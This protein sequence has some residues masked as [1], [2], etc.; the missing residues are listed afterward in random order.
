MSVKLTPEHFGD[1]TV[2]GADG[3]ITLGDGAATMRDT[4]RA[5]VDDGKKKLVLVVADVSYIDSSGLGELVCGHTYAKRKGAKIKLAT[6]TK[7]VYDLLQITKLYVVFE[8]FDDAEAAVRSF[9]QTR[10]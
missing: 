2:I 9:Q 3:T 1:V 7:R 8:V 5:L 4:I 6:L 10:E